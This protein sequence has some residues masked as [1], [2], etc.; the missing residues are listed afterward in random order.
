MADSILYNS[1]VTNLNIARQNCLIC[2]ANDTSSGAAS[3]SK[4]WCS[5]SG[6]YTQQSTSNNDLKAITNTTG[7]TSYDFIG[8]ST[9]KWPG[10]SIGSNGLGSAWYTGYNY[11]EGC[12]DFATSSAVSLSDKSNKYVIMGFLLNSSVNHGSITDLLLGNYLL[13]EIEYM[14][15]NVENDGVNVGLEI[16]LLKA[17]GGATDTW[18]D[19][20]HIFGT[21]LGQDSSYFP[22]TDT[23]KRMVFQIYLDPKY[24][25]SSGKT[26]TYLNDY[27]CFNL[28]IIIHAKTTNIAQWAGVRFRKFNVFTSMPT[29]AATYHLSQQNNTSFVN[30]DGSVNMNSVGTWNELTDNAFAYRLNA[31]LINSSIN[32]SNSPLG[33]DKQYQVQAV[34][35]LVNNNVETDCSWQFDLNMRGNTGNYFMSGSVYVGYINKSSGSFTPIN[36]TYGQYIYTFMTGM[37]SGVG[38][39]TSNPQSF[40][41]RVPAGNTTDGKT[42]SN[43]VSYIMKWNSRQIIQLLITNSSD[44][45]LYMAYKFT[46]YPTTGY[47]INSFSI[48]EA[49]FENSNYKSTYLETNKTNAQVY[50]T[51]GELIDNSSTNTHLSSIFLGILTTDLIPIYT[52][53]EGLKYANNRVGPKYGDIGM[54]LV[55]NTI[56]SGLRTICVDISKMRFLNKGSWMCKATL[57]V[58]NGISLTSYTSHAYTITIYKDKSA[59]CSEAEGGT[60]I[61]IPVTV[62]SGHMWGVRSVVYT[63]IDGDKG[64][65]ISSTQNLDTTKTVTTGNTLSAIELD[66]SIRAYNNEETE[67]GGGLIPSG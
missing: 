38:K 47:L 13:F 1:S 4:Y 29:K 30:S 14:H 55:V 39:L 10:Y 25:L 19:T 16:K 8:G 58:V 66:F 46:M 56:A 41:W 44:N 22:V 57:N 21:L 35:N 64:T 33:T 15:T 50:N 5:R 63:W 2:I 9:Q 37:S 45:K 32:N 43:G 27:L 48:T 67:G 59:S 20:E 18:M 12:M 53:T 42:D 6:Y 3:Y 28:N 23:W 7:T 17:A 65:N 61:K 40:G 54:D 52:V 34:S 62:E 36:T 31:G 51:A 49:E 26:A 11:S 24:F 60:I